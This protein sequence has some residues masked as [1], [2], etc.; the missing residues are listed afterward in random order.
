MSAEAA[1]SYGAALWLGE[2]GWFG[3]PE[4]DGVKVQRF[5]AA[6][7]RLG[8]GGAFWVW[9]QGCGSPETGDDAG[10][11]GNLV[12]VDCATGE[13]SPPPAGFAVPLSRAY[14]QAFPGHLDSLVSDGSDLT[15]T[16]T[17]D[18]PDVNCQ[19]DVWVPGRREPSAKHR[20]VT[21]VAA[22]RAPA[23]AQGHRPRR[24]SYTVTV[25][26]AGALRRR[27]QDRLINGDTLRIGAARRRFLVARALRSCGHMTVSMVRRWCRRRRRT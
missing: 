20:G 17:V 16:A 12:S 15:F 7:D 19:F 11:S 22:T 6:Q 3:D 25:S 1:K 4:V 8:V 13:L 26:Q 2:W 10:R 18:D 14:P 27:T 9:R 21:D 24:A 5:V 23:A